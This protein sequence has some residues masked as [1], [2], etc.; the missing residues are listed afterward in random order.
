MSSLFMETF[1][2]LLINFVKCTKNKD[3]LAW[4]VKCNFYKCLILSS[5]CFYC[6]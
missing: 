3:T 1:I 4:I 6:I 5:V 2:T